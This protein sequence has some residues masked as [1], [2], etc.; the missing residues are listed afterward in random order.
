[1]RWWIVLVLAWL[2]AGPAVADPAAAWAALREGG[3]V[4]LMRHAE[5]PGVGD[6]PGFDLADCRTQRN[7]SER[8]RADAT[9]AGER[10]R[11]GRIRIG[12]LLSSPWCRCKDT[13]ELLR[14][15]SFSIEPAFSNALG[16][17]VSEPEWEVGRRILRAW[18]GPGTLLVVTHG[19]TIRGLLDGGSNPASG[20]VVVVRAMHDGSLREVGRLMLFGP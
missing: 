15:G 10:L 1:M 7:L 3:H 4:A 5:A 12:Q 11:S 19:S 20:E 2:S 16:R 18:K 14:I 8:G 17:S 6:P 13:A 9:A